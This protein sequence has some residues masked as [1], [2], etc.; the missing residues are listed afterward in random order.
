[1]R[2]TQRPD[3]AGFRCGLLL[4]SFLFLTA[5]VSA[6]PFN[7]TN[8]NCGLI[9]AGNNPHLVVGTVE[10]IAT[11]AQ[12]QAVYR[13]ARAHG[14]WKSLP[15][16]SHAYLSFV[17]PVS[18]SVP[19]PTGPR[20]VTVLMTSE[21]FKASPLKPGALVRYSPHDAAHEAITYENA[22]KQA[23]WLLVGCV[24]QL[25]APG[26]GDCMGRYRGG[27]YSRDSGAQLSIGSGRPLEGGTV[28]NPLTLLPVVQS[29]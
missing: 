22:A 2:T 12:V 14:Y 13:W 20:S 25:C 21:E 27:L 18:L 19:T 4:L 26:D 17:Q 10:A 1:M 29:H 15:A 3:A 24:A 5:P 8:N 11:P 28:I 23:Y 16:T 7:C 9:V 6:A